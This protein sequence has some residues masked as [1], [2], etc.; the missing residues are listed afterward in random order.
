MFNFKALKNTLSILSLFL[1]STCLEVDLFVYCEE[2][3]LEFYPHMYK[4]LR[5]SVYFDSA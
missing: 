3:D 5:F 2:G 1:I 4:G